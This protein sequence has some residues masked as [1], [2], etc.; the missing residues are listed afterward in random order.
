M[1]E[2]G[3]IKSIIDALTEEVRR[4]EAVRCSYFKIELGELSGITEDHLRFHLEEFSKGTVIDG[5]SV[6]IV[7]VPMS[8]SC[9]SCGI[10]YDIN[11]TDVSVC[12]SCKSGDISTTTG[13]EL[14]IVSIETL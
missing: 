11:R 4:A 6:D 2:S 8:L 1:H 12:P 13:K 10:R 5:A 7:V 14:D 9:S 3:L